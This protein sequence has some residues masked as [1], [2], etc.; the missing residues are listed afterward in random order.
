[1]FDRDVGSV[2]TNLIQCHGGWVPWSIVCKHLATGKSKVWIPIRSNNPEV[3]H[4]W[5]CPSCETLFDLH[6]WQF[7]E[8]L[9]ELLVP[10]CIHCVR[11]LRK[12]NDP[13]YK[14]LEDEITQS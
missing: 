9:C 10:V 14:E 8:E 13:K 4:D 6:D 7:S 3:D 11:D 1:M 2:N 12:T 5:V